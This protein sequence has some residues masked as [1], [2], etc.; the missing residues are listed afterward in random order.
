MLTGKQIK[1][2]KRAERSDTQPLGSGSSPSPLQETKRDAVLVVT[3]WV[4]ELRRK[5]F[6]E[7]KNGFDSLFGNAT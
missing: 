5:K 4:S 6:E 1:I 2:I 3:E 7:A